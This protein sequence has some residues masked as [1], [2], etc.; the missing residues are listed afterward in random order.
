MATD[1]ITPRRKI[2]KQIGCDPAEIVYQ[3]VY[4]QNRTLTD[5]GRRFGVHKATASRWLRDYEQERTS[6]PERVP[7]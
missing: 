1:R 4:L 7:A 5:A 3:M 6:E 2:Q